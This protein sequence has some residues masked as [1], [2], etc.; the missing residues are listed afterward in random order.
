MDINTS[1]FNCVHRGFNTTNPY[2]TDDGVS[3]TI[4]VAASRPNPTPTSTVIRWTPPL[5]PC[6]LGVPFTDTDTVY[7]GVGVDRTTIVTGTGL[8]PPNLR[9]PVWLY[10]QRDPAVGGLGAWISD[11]AL[12]INLWA[13]LMALPRSVAGELRYLR[14]HPVPA[15]FSPDAPRFTGLEWRLCP[16]VWAP[17]ICRIPFSRTTMLAD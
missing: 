8:P 4:E 6:A 14:N 11:S 15:V 9:Q 5:R 1:K 3:R 12:A 7:F 16:A 17:T 2:F 10:L 13:A